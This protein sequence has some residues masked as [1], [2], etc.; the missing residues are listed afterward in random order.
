[1]KNKLDHQLHEVGT[2]SSLR[3]PAYTL[4]SHVP[5]EGSKRILSLSEQKSGKKKP[6]RIV[7]S[8]WRTHSLDSHLP[9]NLTQVTIW[10]IVVP[11]V[12]SIFSNCFLILFSILTVMLCHF[13][14]FI[15]T[16]RNNSGVNLQRSKQ[17]L[18]YI[19]AVRQTQML[20]SIY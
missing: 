18:S 6:G 8:R 19:P 4:L 17:S 20:R 13:R 15:A 14:Y 16:Q 7:P 11:F 2:S 5:I 3:R 12:N 10:I 9:S 1:M